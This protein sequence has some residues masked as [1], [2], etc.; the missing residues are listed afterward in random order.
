VYSLKGPQVAKVQSLVKYELHCK[1]ETKTDY[2]EI[3]EDIFE[4]ELTATA[5]GEVMKGKVE[6][7]R[8]GVFKVSFRGRYV[9]EYHFNIWIRGALEKKTN[10]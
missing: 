4:A 8:K 10:I 9:G 3:E 1:D 5:K 7:E 6:K 2:V